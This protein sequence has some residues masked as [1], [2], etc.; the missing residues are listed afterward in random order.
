MKYDLTKK[1]KLCSYHKMCASTAATAAATPPKGN[2][3][4]NAAALL[5]VVVGTALVTVATVLLDVDGLDTVIDGP[6]TLWLLVGVLA[7]LPPTFTPTR[8]AT[9]VSWITVD[10]EPRM[11]FS[12][13]TAAPPASPH[14]AMMSAVVP[15]VAMS[16]VSD[17]WVES[18]TRVTR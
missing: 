3:F 7:M 2:P 16:T 12:V 14:S 18:S 13:H 6:S 11:R 1:A 9:V 8:L 10:C 5:V 4:P 17:T 15:P